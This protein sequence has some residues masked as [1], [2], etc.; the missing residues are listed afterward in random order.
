M[1][2]NSVQRQAVEHPGG[3]LL[4]LAGAGSGKTRVLTGRIAHLVR[5]RGVPEGAILAFTFTNKAAREM[6]GR[7]ESLLGGEDLRVWLGTFH[8][9]C[10]RILRRH[11]EA[12]GYPR[13]FVI[14][15]T[16]DQRSLLR[17]LLRETGGEDRA[18][19][20]AAAGS[21]ISRLKNEGITPETFEAEARG[22]ID[23][24]LAP[25]YTRYAKGLRDRA[26]MDFDDLL[27]YTV[28]LFDLDE[29][30]HRM[31]AERFRHVLVDEYQDTNAIQ[32]EL[33][34]RLCRV[35]RNLTVVG[36]DDQSIYGWRG[37]S[38]ENI[39]SFE[40]RY[41]EATVLRLTQ[42]YRSTQTILRAA[43]GVVRNNAGRKEKELW[44]ENVVG[45]PLTLHVL[46]DEEAE[47]EKVVS[48]LLEA[49]R[50]QGR[51]NRD[52]VVLYRTNAQSR[53][54]E[55]ALR[56]SAIPY[57]LTGGISFYERREVK[58]VL[59]YLR[60]LVQP[61]DSISWFRIL[62]V[63]PRGI[64]KTTLDRLRDFMEER[65]LSVPEAIGHSELAAVTGAASAKKL[66]EAGAFL[67]SLRDLTALPPAVCVAELLAK[68]RFREYLLEENPSE[69]AERIENVEEL[70][71]GAEAYARR[72]EEPTL[73]GFLAEVSLLTDVD[74]W[75]D[76]DDTV[77]IMTIHAAKGLEFP[78]VLLVGLEEGLLPHASSL[79]DPK[80][81]EEE[82]RLFYVALTRAQSEVRLLHA[83]YRRAWNASGGGMSRF[84][85]EIPTDCV[86]IDQ[87][88]P[89]GA[90][91]PR[92]IRRPASSPS[93]NVPSP[94]G[95]RVLHPQ[96]GE[97]VVV[98]CE[99]MGERAKL[100]VQFRRAGVKKILA[101]FAELSHAD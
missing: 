4:I 13:G 26:A 91:R 101:A 50:R 89:W 60:A 44:T 67:E 55:N 81:L 68:V 31:Y 92:T 87:A 45:E 21:R 100:T 38:V 40:K 2:L 5:E 82:R 83:T 35:H 24:R 34:E 33:I 36:D 10:V 54:V 17:E 96:F 18:L 71:A 3:P 37:A 86:V 28:R 72:A 59:A 12:L 16:D 61:R 53:A 32:F 19:T 74:L 56:R 47:G 52:F 11:A 58:D 75:N 80:Q 51:S 97:G 73:D 84:V 30:V 7:V 29:S 88:D 43:N 42:N 25:I 64:G 95:V 65:G 93:R 23:R 39:L 98:A 90:P 66:R 69:A 79:E 6:R 1:D 85:S 63:P 46:P 27:L 49:R 41:P 62:N 20:P 99:G 76:A 94:V 22:P 57:Q 9:T 78:V 70:I 15:D 14:Y 8:A 48:I 77:N